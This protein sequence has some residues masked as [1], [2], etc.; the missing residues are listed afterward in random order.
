M[1]QTSDAVESCGIPVLLLPVDLVDSALD[2]SEPTAEDLAIIH[3][4]R[5][6]ARAFLSA[7]V[8]GSAFV[9]SPYPMTC[10][11]LARELRIAHAKQLC[12]ALSVR[13]RYSH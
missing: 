2:V 1:L 3:V 6:L 11:P 12:A 5:A 9:D 4:A 10:F 8:I 13:R 7:V